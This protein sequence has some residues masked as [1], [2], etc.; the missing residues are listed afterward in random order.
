[1]VRKPDMMEFVVGYE[2]LGRWKGSPYRTETSDARDGGGGGGHLNAQGVGG[3]VLV[4]ELCKLLVLR[5]VDLTVPATVPAGPRQ[6]T[7]GERQS[8]L[9]QVKRDNVVS[10]CIV[11]K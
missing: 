10:V 1:M 4:E 2:S 3:N 5:L 9:Q 8:D 6:C 7:P 11:E